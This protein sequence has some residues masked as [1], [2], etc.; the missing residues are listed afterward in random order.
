MPRK[1]MRKMYH[2]RKECRRKR[3]GRLNATSPYAFRVLR[4]KRENKHTIIA[5]AVAQL[6]EPVAVDSGRGK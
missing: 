1:K 2:W 4:N 6:P 3:A 5:E